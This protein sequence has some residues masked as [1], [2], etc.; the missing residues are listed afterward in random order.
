VRISELLRPDAVIA[1]L[2]GR[3][4]PEALAELC[5]PLGAA[6]ALEP[7][8]LVQVLLDRERLGSTGIGEGVAIPHGKL[9]GLPGIVAA[10]GRSREGVDF[11]SVDGQPARLILALFAPEQSAGAHL[12]ALARVSRLFRVQALREALLAAPDAQSMVRLLEE[13]EAREDGR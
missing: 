11:R 3:T 10:L 1:D 8:R 13:A 9:A 4:A 6:T 7:G 12:Q 5:R 2:G